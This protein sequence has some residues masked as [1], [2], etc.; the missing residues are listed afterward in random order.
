MQL[1]CNPLHAPHVAHRL[2]DRRKRVGDEQKTHR[3]GVIQRPDPARQ[4]EHR[5][6]AKSTS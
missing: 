2:P 4:R 6:D 5:S 3:A 1:G